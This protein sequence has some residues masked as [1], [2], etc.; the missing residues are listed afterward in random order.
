LHHSHAVQQSVTLLYKGVTLVCSETEKAS[1]I[2]NFKPVSPVMPLIYS[3]N[4]DTVNDFHP[5]IINH[6]QA[7]T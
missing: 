6:F 5:L 7:F 2:S 1:H 4:N 3:P